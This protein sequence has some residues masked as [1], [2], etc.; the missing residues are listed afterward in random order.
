MVLLTF[1]IAHWGL[2]LDTVV[3]ERKVLPHSYYR[4]WT[5]KGD[6]NGR[7]PEGEASFQY[8]R[9]DGTDVTVI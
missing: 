7:P 3:G 2:V 8:L 1:W 4:A 5:G 9:V 6:I